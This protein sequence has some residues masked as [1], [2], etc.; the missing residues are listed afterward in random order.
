MWLSFKNYGLI[1]VNKNTKIWLN[2]LAGGAI[3]VFLLWSI[4]AQVNKQLSGIS[5]DAW[6][7]TGPQFWLVLCISLMFV[8]TSL[9]GYKW[10]LLSRSVEPIAY[11]QAF[12]SY[13]AGVAFSIVTPNRVGEYPG[14]ILYLGRTHTFKYITVSILGIMAQLSGVYIFGLIGLIYYNI[15]FPVAIAKIALV[16]CISANILFAIIY[17]RFETWM[18]LI[19]KIKWLRRFGIYGRLLN[20][21]TAARQL[22]ILG[23]SLLRCTIFTAQY[24]FLLRWMNVSIP[25]AEGFCMAA[26]FFWVIAIIPS[27]A[28]TGFVARAS[29]SVY[30]F[31]HF[32]PNTMGI[33]AAT[34]GI[35]LLNLVIPS[36][37]GSILIF[38]MRLLR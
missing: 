22:S 14:R 17:W 9:E 30:L 19:E 11:K 37:I 24:L 7:Q 5:A 34:T 4:Y 2:Y 32:S 26:L 3:S 13:L 15:F 31:Q 29:V 21:I 23:I 1:V 27:I 28:F 18:P 33:L 8:N 35:W 10:F 6:K 25:L 38:R 36:I 20:R 16:L 12:S